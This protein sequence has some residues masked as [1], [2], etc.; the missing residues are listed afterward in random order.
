MVTPIPRYFKSYYNA[1]SCHTLSVSSI[2]VL[3]PNT[4]KNQLIRKKGCFQGIISKDEVNGPF[5]SMAFGSVV[6][7]GIPVSMMTTGR[8]S[9]IV[10]PT[11]SGMGGEAQGCNIFY[12]CIFSAN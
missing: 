7:Q 1:K 5:D 12:N 6:K 11:T 9:Q 3:V 8:E 2:S 4:D 10:H